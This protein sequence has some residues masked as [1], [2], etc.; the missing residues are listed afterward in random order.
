[1]NYFRIVY[2]DPDM[3]CWDSSYILSKDI[4]A[5]VTKAIKEMG[6]MKKH[7]MGSMKKHAYI[8]PFFTPSQEGDTYIAD[9]L[10]HEYKPHGLS[11]LLL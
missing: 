8:W 3:L 11:K 1:M 10:S 7:A 4:Q 2:F 9:I 6:S 5:A